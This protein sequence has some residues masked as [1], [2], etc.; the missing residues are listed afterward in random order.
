MVR[1]ERVPALPATVP[2]RLHSNAAVS[3]EY[4]RKPEHLTIVLQGHR[5]WAHDHSLSYSD[6]VNAGAGRILELIDF[7]AM[8]SIKKVTLCVF[9]DD[10][11]LLP[12]GGQ[13]DAFGSFMR[14]IT[15]GA[16]N[17]HRNDVRLQIEGALDGL[18]AITRGLLNHVARRTNL[19]KGM[20][21]IV[22]INGLVDPKPSLGLNGTPDDSQ[23]A[24]AARVM[25]DS[26]PDFVIRTGGHMPV[27][28]TMLW[29][30]RKTALYF[31]DLHWPAFD[32]KSLHA[33]LDWYG[34]VQRSVGIQLTPPLAF[35]ER[36][37]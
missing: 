24:D 23:V 20:Q 7:C 15:A 14:Y 19:N 6:A 17:L 21:L 4:E 35:Q 8:W 29:E 5:Q 36:R 32:A 9:T 11:L 3:E 2:M 12:Q 31:T 18:D 34:E 26:A 30:T 16:Q 13:G 33:A 25:L 22:A 10:L 1:E 37:H 28:R 27:H